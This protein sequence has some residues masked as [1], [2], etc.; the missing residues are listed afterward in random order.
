MNGA[1]GTFTKAEQQ[2][3]EPNDYAWYAERDEVE[4]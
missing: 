2:N 3:F 1:R 4:D